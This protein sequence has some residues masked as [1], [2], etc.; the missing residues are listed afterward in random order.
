MTIIQVSAKELLS[1]LKDTDS[2]RAH[3][4]DLYLLL[5]LLGG[6]S[7]QDLNLLKIDS[8]KNVFLKENLEKLDFYWNEFINKKTPIQYLCGKTYWRDLKLKVSN[9]VLIPRKETE[10]IVDIVMDLCDVQKNIL[11]ADLGTG[12]GAIAISIAELNQNWSGLATDVNIKAL[13]I[14]F[15]Q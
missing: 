5:D 4:Y 15:D 10:Q 1:W 7:K 14:N 8:T 11:F 9:D 13:N 6:I 12:S 3:K 2:K